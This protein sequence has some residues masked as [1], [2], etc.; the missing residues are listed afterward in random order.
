MINIRKV[1]DLNRD[2]KLTCLLYGKPGSGKTTFAL[3]AS[4]P[5]IL[6]CEDGLD[7]RVAFKDLIQAACVKINSWNDI[8]NIT[9]EDVEPYDTII[10]D[11]FG[12][13]VQTCIRAYTNGTP[14]QR[15]W[16]EIRDK[17]LFEIHK[18]TGHKNVIATAHVTVEDIGSSTN[19]EK[20]LV[21]QAQGSAIDNF[22]NECQL[23]GFVSV[24]DHG[25]RTVSFNGTTNVTG[26]NC[27][28]LPGQII[29]PDNTH[30]QNV[31]FQQLIERQID[32]YH[33]NKRDEYKQINDAWVTIKAK[34]DAATTPEHFTMIRNE[35][36]TYD[37]ILSGIQDMARRYLNE[38][39]KQPGFGFVFDNNKFSMGE[40]SL[41]EAVNVLDEICDS[42]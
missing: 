32:K 9:L 34:I 42:L 37:G 25:E 31:A 20:R 4:N 18:Y 22:M 16:G 19:P 24:N 5:L 36:L 2:K 17:V 26:K 10:F 41:K 11:T 6:D 33:S 39:N 38:K 21:P 23:I 8:R 3:S 15:Q 13:L 14:T 30:T 40:R 35:W 12:A 1:E 27:F 29:I 7:D 28:G